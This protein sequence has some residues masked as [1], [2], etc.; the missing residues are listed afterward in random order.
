MAMGGQYLQDTA[1]YGMGEEMEEDEEMQGAKN[2]EQEEDV[3]MELAGARRIAT[4]VRLNTQGDAQLV[5]DTA[6]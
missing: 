3:T 4:G 5:Y 6:P 2:S 1:M